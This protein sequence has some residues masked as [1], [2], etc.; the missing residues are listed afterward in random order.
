MFGVHSCVITRTKPWTTVANTFQGTAMDVLKICQVKLVYLSNHRYGTLCAKT[1]LDMPSYF[2]ANYNYLPMLQQPPPLPLIRELETTNTL[3]DMQA[4]PTTS[5]LNKT[6]IPPPAF[7][8]PLVP[9]TADAMDKI[10]GR[11]DVCQATDLLIKDAMDKV[12]FSDP[13]HHPLNVEMNEN[14]D[15]LN[16]ILEEPTPVQHPEVSVETLS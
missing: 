10:V 6:A 2:A 7:E 11:F 16:V 3:L 12:V 4:Q 13:N 9:E 5:A 15:E 8:G 14:M 1:A